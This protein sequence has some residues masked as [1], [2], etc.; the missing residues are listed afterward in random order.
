MHL[1]GTVLFEEEFGEP[2]GLPEVHR[3][4]AYWRGYRDDNQRI[5]E[6]LFRVFS[7]AALGVLAEVILWATQLLFA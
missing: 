6:R 3:R 5:I 2:G 4:L 1:R 7:A